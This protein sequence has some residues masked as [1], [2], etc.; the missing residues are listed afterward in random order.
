MK[1]L[2]P[3]HLEALLPVISQSP[4]FSLLDMQLEALDFGYC[5]LSILLSPKHHN[6]LGG[7]HGGVYASAIDSAAYW[8]NYCE[9][10]EDAGLISLDLHVDNLSVVK[11]GKLLVEGFKLKTGRRVCLSEARITDQNGKLLAHGTSKQL[12]T[13]GQGFSAMGFPPRPPTFCA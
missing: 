12:I 9:L 1:K 4:Y 2:N 7:P 5:R 10:E 11:E 8:A 13:P 6:L 3:A